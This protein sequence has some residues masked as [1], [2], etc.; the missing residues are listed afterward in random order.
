[1]TTIEQI[2]AERVAAMREKDAER[3]VAAYAPGVV[4]FDLAPPLSTTG[5]EVTDPDG[6]RS[7]FGG[8]VGPLGYD[9]T[10]LVVTAGADV[11]FCHS[12]NR[13]AAT[14]HGEPEGF[15]MWYRATVGLRVVDGAWKITH[16]HTSTPFYMDGSFLAATDLKP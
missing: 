16:E 15:E 12:L 10:E 7:W 2:V 14:P 6:I 3:V 13:L 1:M 8:F 4:R 11:A 9:V 5:A